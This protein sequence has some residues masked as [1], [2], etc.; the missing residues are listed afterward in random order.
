MVNTNNHTLLIGAG[1]Y[2][3]SNPD[4][5][6]RVSNTL[7]LTQYERST[8]YTVGNAGYLDFRE[9]GKPLDHSKDQLVQNRWLECV[10]SYCP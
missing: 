1:R 5:I 7:E 2:F 3:T 6:N 8:F 9:F 4:L 10:D